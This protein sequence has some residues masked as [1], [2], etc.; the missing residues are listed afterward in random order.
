MTPHDLNKRLAEIVGKTSLDER[1]ARVKGYRH[2]GL[3][4]G[5][6]WGMDPERQ[7]GFYRLPKWSS[8][9]DLMHELE[10]EFTQEE[11]RDY[12]HSLDSLDITGGGKPWYRHLISANAEQKAK[13]W[14]KVKETT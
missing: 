9:L 8:S 14:L 1:I 3:V 4:N 11:W 7:E 12:L 2:V 5:E 10:E 13:A 6:P